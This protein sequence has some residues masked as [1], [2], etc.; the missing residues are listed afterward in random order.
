MVRGGG[1]GHCI[2]ELT[3]LAKYDFNMRDQGLALTTMASIVFREGGGGGL[4][5][6]P[7]GMR[8]P[9]KYAGPC[10][11]VQLWHRCAFVSPQS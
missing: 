3:E 6:T 5:Q 1:G 2:S 9:K 7:N 4:E 11:R 8:N 10:I